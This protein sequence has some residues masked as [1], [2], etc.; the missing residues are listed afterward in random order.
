MNKKTLKKLNKYYKKQLQKD[1]VDL[2]NLN[3]DNFLKII[4]TRLR[5]LRDCCLINGQYTDASKLVEEPALLALCSA[6]KEY[7]EYI[8][9]IYNYYTPSTTGVLTAKDPKIDKTELL[10]MFTQEKQE[11]L[12]CFLLLLLT[13]LEEWIKLNETTF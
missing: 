7:D 8:T 10:N 12:S 4:V 13:N 9:C 5:Y 3:D 6:I 11:H 2:I 1:L